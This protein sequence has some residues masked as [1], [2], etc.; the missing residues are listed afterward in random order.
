MRTLLLAVVLATISVA[1]GVPCTRER[2]INGLLEWV[3][4]DLD[5]RLSAQEFNAVINYRPC[6]NDPIWFVGEYLVANRSDGGCSTTGSGYLEV[7]DFDATGSC[8]QADALWLF[9]CAKLDQCE[10]Y[11]AV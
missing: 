1:V 2:I 11:N 7:A 9:I 3:D 10:A 6:G 4:T 5:G 8:M